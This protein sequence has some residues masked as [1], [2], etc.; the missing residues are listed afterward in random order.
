MVSWKRILLAL[1]V[2][3]RDSRTQIIDLQISIDE[4]NSIFPFRK[5]QILISIRIL[6]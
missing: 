3:C 1:G 4:I 6:Q 2:F 5:L